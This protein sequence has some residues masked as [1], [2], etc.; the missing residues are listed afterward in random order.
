MSNPCH[1]ILMFVLYQNYVY[2]R[3]YIS[4]IVLVV[5]IH[6]KVPFSSSSP[7]KTD[8][9]A[10]F[11]LT[12]HLAAT[13]SCCSSFMYSSQLF[14]KRIIQ[15]QLPVTYRLEVQMPWTTRDTACSG[16]WDF[17]LWTCLLARTITPR[18]S[19]EL[20]SKIP[21]EKQEFANSVLVL[22]NFFFITMY[23]SLGYF[24]V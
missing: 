9:Q 21:R 18:F 1:H 13:K 15:N 3:T 23:F 8:R 22:S 2:I 20:C 24:W 14:I 12:L 5:F 7:Y 6:Q 11:V 19:R 16:I 4:Y 17:A 10:T